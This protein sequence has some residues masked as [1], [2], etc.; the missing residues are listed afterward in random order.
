MLSRSVVSDFWD[1]MDCTPP[2]CSVHGIL[3]A[4]TLEWVASS[5]S[6]GSS[7]PR[8]R[9][10]ASCTGRQIL[11]CLSHRGSTD[12]CGFF[13][14]PW[15]GSEKSLP[16]C[17]LTQTNCKLQSQ[18]IQEKAQINQW[19]IDLNFLKWYHSKDYIVGAKVMRTAGRTNGQMAQ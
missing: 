8:Y 19:G 13:Q 1:P 5:F 14:G 7:P 15:A 10:W 6:R 16:E 17:C 3:Q 18:Q 9:T 2:G 12:L 11:Y 4:R